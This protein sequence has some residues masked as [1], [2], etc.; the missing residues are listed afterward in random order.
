[1]LHERW[2]DERSTVTRF[3]SHLSL[4]LSLCVSHTLACAGESA[5]EVAEVAEQPQQDAPA[6][7]EPAEE[8]ALEGSV[9]NAWA[10]S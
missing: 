5:A 10:T 8:S 7:E 9:E 4:S 3:G 2:A 6:A 1:M